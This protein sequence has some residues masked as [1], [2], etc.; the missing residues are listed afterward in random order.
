[1]TKPKGDAETNHPKGSLV[2]VSDDERKKCRALREK[3]GWRQEDIAER[4][5]VTP[6]TIS[7]FESG[8]SRQIRKAV[9]AKLKRALRVVEDSPA[10]LDED[11]V[12]LV[13]DLV[14]LDPN[15][16]SVVAALIDSLKKRRQS[17]AT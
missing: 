12:Q 8:R 15:D 14:E 5:G 2:T 9:Y 13:D 10:Q 7:N 17:G 11:F 3:R 6:A 1:M 4:I 16:Q